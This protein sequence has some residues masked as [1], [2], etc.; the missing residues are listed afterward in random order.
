[1]KKTMWT[2]S[3]FS[4]VLTVIALQCMPDSVPLH[5]DLS[6]TIDRWGSKY[7]NLLF[8]AIILLFSLHWHL[9]TA[10]YEKK[11]ARTSVEKERVEALSNAKVLKI[12]GALMAALFTVMQ[13]FIL[14][15]AYME[16]R[17]DATRAY[18]D[19]GKSS[20]ILIG[21]MLIILGNYMPKTRKN[22][23]AG[24]RIR[25][26]LYNDIT[27]RKS[28]R[29]GGAAIMIAGLLT[30]ITTLFIKSDIAVIML[31]LYI[32]TATAITIIYSHKVYN[33]EFSKSNPHS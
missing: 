22:H 12:T 10:H 8:P 32:L 5:Y 33:A 9:L 3:I 13:C 29:F 17:T 6:G 15:S 21:V 1:M 18:V 20:C 31:L 23:I 26:S 2:I 7:E 16:A 14:Y 28:N 30:I 4:L 24:I 19:I 27:W 11:A 25:W